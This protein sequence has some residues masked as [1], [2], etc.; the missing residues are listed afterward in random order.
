MQ[1]IDAIITPSLLQRMCRARIPWPSTHHISGK[2]LMTEFFSDDTRFTDAAKDAW[3]ALKALSSKYGPDT[4]PDMAGFLPVPQDPRFP[5]QAFGMH[6]LLDQAPRV[7][8][9]GIDGRWT[10]WFDKVARA[11][12][13]SYYGL[14]ARLMPWAREAWAGSGS[15]FEYW[16][17]IA[18]EFNATMA[19]QES[20]GDQQLSAIRI[21]TLRRAVEDFS[22]HRDPARDGSLPPLDEYSL[23]DIVTH[24][25]LDQDWPFHKAAF[26]SLRVDDAH[27]PIIDR[28][29][30]YPYRNAIEGRDSTH[31]EL[32]WICNTDHFGEA[33]PEVARR[34]RRD[35]AAGTWA[36]LGEGEGEERAERD[37]VE[38]IQSDMSLSIAIRTEPIPRRVEHGNKYLFGPYKPGISFSQQFEY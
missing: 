36:P 34:V 7:L 24:V 16:L 26:F 2:E 38:N 10:S 15:T 25:D 29:G 1:D 37:A 23:V 13:T 19:H 30:R 5:E 6:V 33:I 12:Y 18:S 8:F 17:C 21:E 35:M 9:K 22:G 27:G 4:V 11:L 3:P 32:L 14:P 28:F 31:D 20:V